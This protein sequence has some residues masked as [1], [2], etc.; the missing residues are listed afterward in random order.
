MLRYAKSKMKKSME[1]ESPGHYDE[2]KTPN[3]LTPERQ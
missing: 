3:E 2:N 1:I